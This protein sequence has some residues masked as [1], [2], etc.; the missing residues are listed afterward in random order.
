MTKTKTVTKHD[1]LKRL[2]LLVAFA[3]DKNAGKNNKNQMC[4]LIETQLG[5]FDGCVSSYLFKTKDNGITSFPKD[6]P[7]MRKAI[8]RALYSNDNSIDSLDTLDGVGRWDE[9]K[10][11]IEQYLVNQS[12]P[13]IKIGSVLVVPDYD[14]VDPAEIDVHVKHADKNQALKAHFLYHSPVAA[15]KWDLVKKAPN[16]KP[17]YELCEKGLRA[18]LGKTNSKVR[19]RLQDY[20]VVFN[21]GAGSPQKD[22][23]ILEILGDGQT[24]RATFAWIDASYPMLH[25]TIKDV[26]PALL[27]DVNGVALLT[28]FEKPGNV[29]KTYESFLRTIYSASPRQPPRGF[30]ETSKV[31]FIL[32][33][34]LSN[35]VEESFF[36][37]YKKVCSHGDLFVF[38]MQFIPDAC[39]NNPD[40]L[41]KFKTK[42]LKSYNFEEGRELAHAGLSL[43]QKYEPTKTSVPP[44][45][46]ELI[47][48]NDK[49]S[50]C[51]RFFV[52][53]KHQ[54]DEENTKTVAT[55]RSVRHYEKDYIKFLSA[56][57]FELFD[58]TE[59]DAGVKTL[60]IEYV[61]NGRSR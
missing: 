17:L 53:L 10:D 44:N 25:R 11:Q 20:R 18:I 21:L 47:F 35:L 7:R 19:A 14:E 49:H 32:G 33:Y 54:E 46:G 16:Y 39:R 52:E 55:A 59:E 37:E 9:L 8:S 27:K 4:G 57:G 24:P 13:N 5:A 6:E 51:V 23:I 34:T 61:G 41:L 30:K 38:P 28:D 3:H 22:N 50:L 1:V 31:F 12:P 15:C 45:V 26:T 58:A 29:A 42:L 36:E 40:E 2:L 48:D 56:N 60:A 43:L